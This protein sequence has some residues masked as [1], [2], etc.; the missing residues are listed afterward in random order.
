[1]PTTS[2]TPTG[3]GQAT[4]VT[5]DRTFHGLNT[6]R[7]ETAWLVWLEHPNPVQLAG[8]LRYQHGYIGDSIRYA[9]AADA[10]HRAGITI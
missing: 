5:P 1:M 4:V 9:L 7:L 10:L 6:D 2:F 3:D 8:V